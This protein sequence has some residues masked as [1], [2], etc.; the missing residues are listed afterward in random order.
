MKLN[1]AHQKEISL[2]QSD[3]DIQNIYLVKLAEFIDNYL[4]KKLTQH[5]ESCF[6]SV[7]G[8]GHSGSTLL[9]NIARVLLHRNNY[10]HLG[11]GSLHDL[12][13]APSPC[14][15]LKGTKDKNF[16][17]L[18]LVPYEDGFFYLGPKENTNDKCALLLKLHDFNPMIDHFMKN[19][20]VKILSARRDIRDCYASH[21]RKHKLRS[22]EQ[23]DSRSMDIL[24]FCHFHIQAHRQWFNNTDYEFVY[25]D[26]INGT[27]E[28]KRQIINNIN[29]VIHPSSV[30]LDV[31]LLDEVVFYVEKKIPEIT[32]QVGLTLE[33]QSPLLLTKYH[34]TNGGK[35]GGYKDTL[36]PEQ[37]ST[38]ENDNICQNFLSTFGYMENND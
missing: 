1:E 20:P 28:I 34:L 33:Q 27:P 8:M 9:Y 3:P 13:L 14:L 19:I 6:V 38:I 12:R 30:D 17:D 10:N 24:D 5:P 25:E 26:Y 36:T 16:E 4:V 29:R 11:F 35:V 23:D 22:A 37:I 31:K 21:Y 2:F 32:K 7:V 18:T 15:E